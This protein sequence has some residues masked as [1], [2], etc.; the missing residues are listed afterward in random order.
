MNCRAKT[1][2]EKNN[3]ILPNYALYNSNQKEEEELHIFNSKLDFTDHI[4]SITA[5]ALL[6][7]GISETILPRFK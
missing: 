1:I 6:N 5:K 7:T 2:S 4:N 3:Q